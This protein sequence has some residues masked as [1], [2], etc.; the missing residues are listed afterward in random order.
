MLR[1]KT[2]TSHLKNSNVSK[3]RF[4]SRLTFQAL[5]SYEPLILLYVN[6]LHYLLLFLVLFKTSSSI[7]TLLMDV[8]KSFIVF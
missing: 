2:Q 7:A 5:L 3:N 4:L 6:L 1:M 8:L